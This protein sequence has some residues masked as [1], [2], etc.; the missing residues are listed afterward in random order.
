MRDAI[1][2]TGYG[3]SINIKLTNGTVWTAK[4]NDV[5][6][7]TFNIID[8][9]EKQHISLSLRQLYYQLVA[10]GYIPNDDKV[11]KKMSKLLTNARY[12]GQVD[13]SSVEDR[14]R[15]EFMP[16]QWNNI[17]SLVESA[18]Y[19]YRLPRWD[20]Q[21]NYIEVITE[22]EALESVLS[23]ICNKWHV[24]LVINKGY[25]SASFMYG[26]AKRISKKIESGKHVFILYLGDHDPSGLDM[27][28]DIEDR[29]REILQNSKYFNCN[30]EEFKIVPIALT[31]KQIDQ[32]NPP[33]NP[34]KISDPR[35]DWYIQKNGEMSWEVDALRPEI[36][37]KIVEDGIIRF[38]D[39]DKYEAVKRRE[40]GEKI[41]L[42]EF[43][44]NMV[45][46]EDE[47]DEDKDEDEEGGN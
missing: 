19:S 23:S 39:K 20:N 47:E 27:I 3:D 31:R 34:A 18:V 17:K 32:Y 10:R 21:D 42:Q 8:E 7:A 46:K 2:I 45:E 12:N 6:N 36:M 43:A 30:D 25:T 38:V 35:A 37:L 41:E 9:Y 29:V 15:S 14:S 16:S 4:T 5:L 11:Y 26:L 33:P 22:K 1:R 44:D 13:W 24:R 40:E 28:R